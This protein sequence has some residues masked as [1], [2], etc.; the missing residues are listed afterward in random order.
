MRDSAAFLLDQDGFS[1]LPMTT[2]VEAHHPAFNRR[3]PDNRVLQRHMDTSATRILFD[4]SLRVA[5][6]MASISIHATLQ[7]RG[8]PKTQCHRSVTSPHKLPSGHDSSP[9]GGV[10]WK[11]PRLERYGKETRPVD[12]A[13]S[14]DE[15]ED[16][17]R[18][19]N[20]ERSR[21]AAEARP[22]Q[23]NFGSN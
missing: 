20:A 14:A 16:L 13:L 22:R 15:E 12:Q 6:V 7:L 11:P 18:Q 10:V 3:D 17:A 8:H 9:R 19:E 1:G 23:S 4:G 21:E 2:L 5:E